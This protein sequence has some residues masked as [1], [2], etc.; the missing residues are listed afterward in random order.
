ME[1]SCNASDNLP[2]HPFSAP[3]SSRRRENKEEP[4][5]WKAPLKGRKKRHGAGNKKFQKG[6]GREPPQKRQGNEPQNAA[7]GQ[8]RGQQKGAEKKQRQETREER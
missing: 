7:K 8:G 3:E 4:P 5:T 1:S 2:Q 6:Q